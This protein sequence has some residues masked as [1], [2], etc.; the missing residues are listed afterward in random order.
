VLRQNARKTARF[1]K[2]ET[3]REREDQHE[4]SHK[5]RKIYHNTS[6]K[7]SLTLS[8]FPTTSSDTPIPRNILAKRI[9]FENFI[10]ISFLLIRNEVTTDLS[11]LYLRIPK[12][13]SFVGHLL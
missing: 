1:Q 7:I 4:Q 6:A 12:F 13:F 2:A 5:A 11:E 10:F 8:E 9:P 3:S